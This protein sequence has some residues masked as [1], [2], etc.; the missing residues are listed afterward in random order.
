[1]KNQICTRCGENLDEEEAENPRIDYDGDVI[2]DDCYTEYF[3][4][5]CPICENYFEHGDFGEGKFHFIL[6]NYPNRVP[7]GIYKAIRF[8]FYRSDIVGSDDIYPECVE[9]IFP[10]SEWMDEKASGQICQNC[11]DKI[12]ESKKEILFRKFV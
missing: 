3:E 12:Y 5:I 4:T 6:T 2:C 11:I 8:P 7:P 9:R 10:A 1:M